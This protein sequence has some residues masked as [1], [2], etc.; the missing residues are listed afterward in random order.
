[1]EKKR[2]E[3]QWERVQT[4]FHCVRG[5]SETLSV[6][7][8]T[9]VKPLGVKRTIII[10]SVLHA[11]YWVQGMLCIGVGKFAAKL[12]VA[13][14]NNWWPDQS[15]QSK[16]RGRHSSATVWWYTWMV[17]DTIHSL[18]WAETGQHKRAVE[19]IRDMLA[20]EAQKPAQP[21]KSHCRSHTIWY[22]IRVKMTPAS[23][24]KP[25]ATARRCQ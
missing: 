14:L 3:K 7:E 24:G 11:R 10:K 15:V 6:F 13:Y 22:S 5:R 16:H 9:R 18:L 2:K 21:S 23:L 12:S 25:A 17:Q 20:A 4:V 1:M 8:M 19:L